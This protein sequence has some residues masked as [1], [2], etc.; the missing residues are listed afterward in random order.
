MPPAGGG[1]WGSGVS[2]RSSSSTSTQ[3]FR[4][5]ADH[6]GERAARPWHNFPHEKNFL[7]EPQSRRGLSQLS[8][9]LCGLCGSARDFAARAGCRRRLA[10]NPPTRTGCTHFD[11][12]P[13]EG[14]VPADR[15][16]LC[17]GTA[18][19]PVATSHPLSANRSSSLCRGIKTS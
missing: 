15:S 9:F 5:G 16:A 19:R 3:G 10:R 14:R 1:A 13:A 8:T 12:L 6:P 2:K 11:W 7:A 18:C 4:L 17:P